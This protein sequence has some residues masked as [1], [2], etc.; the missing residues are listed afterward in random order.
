MSNI[1]SDSDPHAYCSEKCRAE[2]EAGQRG[3]GGDSSPSESSSSGAE[4]DLSPGCSS[5]LGKIVTV[6]GVLMGLIIV[7]SVIFY[8]DE[9]A[10]D[11]AVKMAK[12]EEHLEKRRAAFAEGL[13]EE[14]VEARGLKNFTWEEWQ[15]R[16]RNAQVKIDKKKESLYDKWLKYQALRSEL[17][18]QGINQ[19][20]VEEMG[21]V[22]TTF[23]EFKN[24]FKDKDVDVE[25]KK[26]NALAAELI[27]KHETEI[28]HRAEL[29]NK[30]EAETQHRAVVP[31]AEAQKSG[32]STRL[33]VSGD[34]ALVT[35][36]SE[37]QTRQEAWQE[38]FRAA[39]KS[40]VSGFVG[41]SMGRRRLPQD[42][43]DRF[44]ECLNTVSKADVK[45]YKTL[46]DLQVGQTFSVEIEATIEKKE[47]APKFAK[48]FPDVFTVSTVAAPT[49]PVTVP[50]KPAASKVTTSGVSNGV[51]GANDAVN[52]RPNGTGRKASKD[53]KG[54]AI[55]VQGKGKTKEAALRF[56]VRLAVFRAVYTWV[57]SKSRIDG[58]RDAIKAQ[59][60]TVTEDDVRKFEV[61]DT[62][63]EGGEIVLKVKVHV[64]K[65]KIAPK[66]VKI[67]PDVFGND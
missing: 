67:F 20:K 62:Q 8:K 65:K 53:S 12:W 48:V 42:V 52:G 26:L 44:E 33:V 47:V 35:V 34:K 24:Q 32:T 14:G 6:V 61:L 3:G 18:H 41:I 60:A 7:L 31:K 55:S 57:D 66:F 17:I 15:N 59:M 43:L 30:R 45:R 1:A 49:N 19:N 13:S 11:P 46:K 58:S 23:D 29:I 22:N 63:Q 10:N 9:N 5:V 21:C 39:V 40:A 38:A 56:A 16:N 64:A 54:I 27:K 36:T 50:V 2:A 28:Q 25:L 51:V 37:G 4:P